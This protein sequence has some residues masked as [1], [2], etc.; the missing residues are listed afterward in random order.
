MTENLKERLNDEDLKPNFS[1]FLI[2]LFKYIGEILLWILNIITHI[3]NITL[4]LRGS[5]CK[6]IRKGEIDENLG[7]RATRRAAELGSF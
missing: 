4:Y 6:R 5:Q 2:K 3:L 7:E 1:G